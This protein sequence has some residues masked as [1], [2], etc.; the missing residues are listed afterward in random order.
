M[1]DPNAPTLDPVE[2]R[3]RRT[4]AARAEDMAPGDSTDDLLDLVRD[5]GTAPRRFGGARRPVLAAAAAVVVLA[6][7]TAGVALAGRDGDRDTGSLATAAEQASLGEADLAAVTAPRALVDAL[8]YERDFAANTLLGIEDA[9]AL[10][11]RDTAQARAD[12]DIAIASFDA[13]VASASDAQPERGQDAGGDADVEASYRPG[14]EGLGALAELRQDIDAYAGPRDLNNIGTADRV[15]DRYAAIVS[16]LLEGQ[17][18]YAGEIEDTS[19]RTGAVA[20]ARGMRLGEQTSQL[21]RIALLASIQPG[22]ESVAELAR[23]RTE[24]QYDLDALV[25]ET[26]GTP[27]EDAAVAVVAD[28]E[29]GGLLDLADAAMDGT[30]DIAEILDASTL[31]DEETWPTFLDAVEATLAA[32]V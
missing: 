31:L 28:V 21:V 5:G 25:T 16:E 2:D 24:V 3:I 1:T 13:E 11:V 14:S 19:V 23:L 15:F 20:Y 17:Q 7:A 32:E 26:A 18:R 22:P 30:G 10:P 6:I 8:R 4:F 29:E 12:T 9:I 27:F